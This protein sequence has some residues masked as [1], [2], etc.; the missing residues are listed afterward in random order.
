M[1]LWL[2]HRGGE[3][4]RTIFIMISTR[5][6]L[7]LTRPSTNSGR[8]KDTPAEILV[9]CAKLALVCADVGGQPPLPWN[10]PRRFSRAAADVPNGYRIWPMN[11][12][13]GN[14]TPVVAL[15]GKSRTPCV[16]VAFG[17][18][19]YSLAVRPPRRVRPTATHPND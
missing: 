8:R 2:D 9:E 7:S 13:M 15:V 16:M 1:W 19:L 17:S 14:V 3:G 12:A 4:S 5:S 6:S 11:E 18:P 10:R